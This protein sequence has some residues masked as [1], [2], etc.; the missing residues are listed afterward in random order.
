MVEFLQHYFQYRRVG[1]GRHAA[2]RFAWLVK[3]G[4]RPIGHRLARPLTV[5]ARASALRL[6]AI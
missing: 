1:F 3:S 6:A 5:Q 4:T 2:L